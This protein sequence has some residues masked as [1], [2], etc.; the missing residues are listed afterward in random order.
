MFGTAFQANAFQNNAFQIYDHR[1]G[2]DGLTGDE[3]KR[4]RKLQ[5]KIEQRQ[6]LLEK[7]IKTA[8]SDRKQAIRDLV[9]PVAKVKINKVQLKQEVEKAKPAFD[10]EEL[11]RSI[12]Y[13]EAQREKIL[14]A[15]A[16]RQELQVLQFLEAKRLAEEDDELATILLLH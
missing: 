1:G 7:A 5:L 10:T 11:S 3:L 8:N 13:L 6:R 12:A 2:D 15:V 9:Y 16:Y 4:L 14:Q